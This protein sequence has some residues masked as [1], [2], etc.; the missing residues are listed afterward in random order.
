MSASFFAA[1]AAA[2]GKYDVVHFHAEGPCAMLWLPKLFGKRCIATIHGL[3]HQ[4]AK[5]GKLASTYIMLGEKCAVKFA[6]EI[7]VLSEGVQN[8][9]KETYGRDT[10]FIPNGVNRPV[11]RKAEL[12]DKKFG[13]KKDDYILFLGRLVPE[14]GITYLIEG[15]KNVKTDKKL[16]I[17][18]G[19]S[20]TDEFANQLKEMAKDDDRI[21]FTGFVQG[22]LLDELYSNAYIYSLPSDLEGMPLSLLEAMSYGNCCLVSDI[23]ECASVVE[24]KIAVA[25]T[26]YVGLSIATLLS[27][28]HQ[29]TAVDIISEKVELINN[30]K[31]P[32]QDDYIEKYLEEKN[33]NLTATLDAEEAYKDADFVV[34]AAPTNYDSK[35][36]F[37]DTSAVE[38]VIKLVIEYNPEAIMVIKSTIPVGYTTSIREKFHC[39]NIIFSP[40]FLRESKALY[41]NLYPSRIIVGT[42]INNAR[43]VKAAHTFAQLLQEGAIKEDIDTLFMGFTEAE[44][45][46]LFANTYLALRVSY[47][48][49]LDTY[50]EMKGL[51]TQQII[52]GVCLDPRI[53][54][55]YNNPSF[56]YGGYCLP[57][58][59]KQLLANYADVPE[60]LIEAIVESNRTRKDFIADRVLELAGAYEANDDW[61]ESK[62]KD[63]V[64][65]VYRLTMKSNSDNFRQS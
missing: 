37:F 58:D 65:G 34:I 23:D 13:L 51:N 26:G 8:Y 28:H 30:K 57:K 60:N 1:V 48:N 36:N 9:F 64:V 38:A 42:D 50:A 35:K 7:I 31:S 18:G 41:D 29:V 56:G 46:K 24:D 5:W 17:A 10:K 61:D 63:V 14:K 21:I 55:H 25:G 53:G 12:I 6:D 33:L 44:A 32:I 22:Q 11:I 20:D 3:D 49:E 2:F 39:D 27:Q 62:E 47:F 4:R 52:N 15:F 19:S 16:V 40:E 54:T 45:V 59:T 43:L